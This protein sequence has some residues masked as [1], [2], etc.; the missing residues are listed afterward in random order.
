MANEA[1][2]TVVG[3]VGQDPMLRKTPNGIPVT[4]FSIA[5]TPRKKVN[6]EW[7]DGET[8]WFRV[9]CWNKEAFS[10]ANEIRKGQRV[11]VIG[12]L[13][14]NTYVDKD[15]KNKFQL[16][17]NADTVGIVPKY[18]AEG[19]LVAPTRVDEEPVDDFP[20]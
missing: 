18:I 6:D 2:I 8:V 19:E 17:I 5:N 11:T 14:V 13:A 7:T 1:V 3:N 15:G 16:E 9:F 4:S 20:W 10:A 12:K